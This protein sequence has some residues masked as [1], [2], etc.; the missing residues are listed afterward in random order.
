MEKAYVTIDMPKTCSNCILSYDHYCC[1]VTGDYIRDGNQDG[2]KGRISTCP[3]KTID[4]IKEETNNGSQKQHSKRAT[5]S[6]RKIT[7]GL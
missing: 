6:N 2:F 4:E 1:I 5:P 7:H 3:L